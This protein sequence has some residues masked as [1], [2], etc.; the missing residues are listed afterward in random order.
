MYTGTSKNMINRITTKYWVRIKNMNR[1]ARGGMLKTFLK[2]FNS[3]RNLSDSIVGVKA[4]VVG[5]D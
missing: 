1:R 5:G 4:G 3:D 2:I